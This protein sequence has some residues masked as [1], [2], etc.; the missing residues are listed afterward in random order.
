MWSEEGE[1][2]LGVPG[3]WVYSRP[4]EPPQPQSLSSWAGEACEVSAEDGDAAPDRGR[5]GRD[6]RALTPAG[7]FQG[8]SLSRRRSSVSLCWFKKMY[9]SSCPG[10]G[11]ILTQGLLH[12]FRELVLP[13]QCA[14]GES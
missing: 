6:G 13:L 5:E 14:C 9:W 7:G 3:G 10:K 2:N 1:S 4:G 11:V 12:A 8:L